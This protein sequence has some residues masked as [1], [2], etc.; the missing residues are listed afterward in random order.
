MQ[1]VTIHAAKTQ[2]SRLIAAAVAGEEVVIAKGGKPIVRL[3][4]I[5]QGRFKIGPLADR[6]T[7]A[8]PDFLTPMGEDD[9]TLWEGGA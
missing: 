8:T 5:P 3:V 2:L 9:L 6:L 7:G 4:A 1:Q